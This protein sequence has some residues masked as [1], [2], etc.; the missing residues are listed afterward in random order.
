MTTKELPTVF[1]LTYEYDCEGEGPIS[2]HRTFE[3]ARIAAERH[4]SESGN[5]PPYEWMRYPRDD[6]DSRYMQFGSKTY[7]IRQTTVE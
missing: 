5:D 2:T 6:D 7:H 4:A 1:V 3:G